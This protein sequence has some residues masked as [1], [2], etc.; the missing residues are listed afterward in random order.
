MIISKET[1]YVYGKRKSIKKFSKLVDVMK[2]TYFL[3]HYMTSGSI[4]HAGYFI[5]NIN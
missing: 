2:N 5:E 1:V 3:P 4:R